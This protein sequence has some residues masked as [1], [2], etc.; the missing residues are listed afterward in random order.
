M[1]TS[2][3]LNCSRTSSQS[4]VGGSSGIA[5]ALSVLVPPRGNVHL[6]VLAIAF[7]V[8]VHSLRRKPLAFGHIKM[9][10]DVPAVTGVGLLHD[11]RIGMKAVVNNLLCTGKGGRNESR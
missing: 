9:L 2:W 7:A 8:V 3:S 1:M 10:E 4:G 11:G 6:T 5:V